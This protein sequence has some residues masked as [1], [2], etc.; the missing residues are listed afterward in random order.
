MYETLREFTSKEVAEDMMQFAERDEYGDLDVATPEISR[1]EELD[2]YEYFVY[3]AHDVDAFPV[4]T[5][6]AL[7]MMWLNRENPRVEDVIEIIKEN[8]KLQKDTKLI[9]TLRLKNPPYYDEHLDTSV[10]LVYG[11]GGSWSFEQMV[12]AVEFLSA[13][14]GSEIAKMVTNYLR[15]KGVRIV[16]VKY[17]SPLHNAWN[18]FIGD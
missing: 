6:R 14:T 3:P 5:R 16:R 18:Q 2:N 15:S 7:V 13:D 9:E 8:Q 10:E 12:G 4:T 11:Y 17:G 1:I